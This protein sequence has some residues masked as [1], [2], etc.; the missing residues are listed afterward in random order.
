MTHL[1]STKQ[2]V[3]VAIVNWNSGSLLARCLDCLNKQTRPPETIL[4][5]DNSSTDDSLSGAEERYPGIRIMRLDTNAGFAAAN[6]R[7]V[8]HLQDCEWIA[9]LNPDAFPEPAWLEKLLDAAAKHPNYSSFGCRMLIDADPGLLDGCGDAYHTSGLVWR[10]GHGQPAQGRA[11]VPREIFSACAAAALYRRSA[12][13]EVGGFDEDYFCYVEDV[14]LGFR[15]RLAGH[16][17]LYVP[18]A[19]VR[20]V[21]SATT[22]RRSDFSVYHGHRNLVWTYFKDMPP[23]LFWLYL[24]QHLLIN[25][26]TMILHTLRGQGGI[27]LRAKRDALLGIPKMWQKR[28]A[29]AG[30][31]RI[32]PLSLRKSMGCGFSKDGAD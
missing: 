18:D 4:V 9:L 13:L 10:V 27:M 1:S 29:L 26:G 15:M 30:Q 16:R 23:L 21:G 32:D 25:V 22:G 8:A 11:L 6:N 20:H 2:A 14:D 3:G 12:F 7:A 19:I 31:C 5:V 24:P 28:K 17:C